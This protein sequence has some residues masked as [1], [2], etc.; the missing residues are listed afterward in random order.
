MTKPIK[1]VIYFFF[2]MG[3]KLRKKF[4]LKNRAIY[5]YVAGCLATVKP[6]EHQ[7]Q[8]LLLDKTTS[9]A[10]LQSNRIFSPPYGK[11]CVSQEPHLQT[12]DKNVSVFTPQHY[13]CYIMSHSTVFVHLLIQG[14]TTGWHAGRLNNDVGRPSV[15]NKKNGKCLNTT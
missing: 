15:T 11:W 13:F 4:F 1:V 8:Y 3:K 12:T 10:L 9:S 2:V 5:I 7:S 14:Y 6:H